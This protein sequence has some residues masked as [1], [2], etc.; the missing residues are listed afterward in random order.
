MVVVRALMLAFLLLVTADGSAVAQA[1][2]LHLRRMQVLD[3]SGFESPVP[4]FVLLAPAGWTVQGG[5]AWRAAPCPLHMIVTHVVVASP[6]GRYALEFFPTQTWTWSSDRLANEVA[7]RMAV[8]GSACPA[9]PAMNA[10]DALR[11][12]YLPAYRP[13]AQVIEA[14]GDAALTAELYR[15][16]QSDLAIYGPQGRLWADAARLRVRT[17][18]SEEWLVGGLTIMA[19]PVPSASLAAEGA[20]G[21]ATAFD[22]LMSVAFAFRAPEG[23]L[24]ASG[25]MLAAMLS[26]I[27]INPAWQAAAS[28]VLLAV[29]QAQLNGAIERA[30]I[31]RDAM[32]EIGEMRMQTWWR[33]QE[34]QDRTA[35]AFSQSLRG[36][37]TYLEPGGAAVELP[38]GY[39]AAWSNGLGDYVLSVSP[40]FSP[41]AALPGQWTEMQ[42]GR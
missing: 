12:V 2:P 21:N 15:G 38:A 16:R 41:Q 27:R 11:Q 1:P 3:P 24:D 39:V 32:Q 23:Q 33:S 31:W 14:R 30:R 4:A 19:H 7:Q 5:V 40:G 22:S 20:L 18:A 29:G 8:A 17:G 6:D 35:A 42:P 28:R 26:S 25:P 34:A 13:G 10:V 9:R 36:V 37:Q